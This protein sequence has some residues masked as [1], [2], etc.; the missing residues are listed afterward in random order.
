MAESLDALSELVQLRTEVEQQGGMINALVRYHPEIKT[1]ILEEF[2]K[3]E[4]MKVIYQLIDG[5]RTQKE[6]LQELQ[7]RSVPNASQ[8]TVS[9]R[10]DRLRDDLNLIVLV[11]RTEGS[12]VYIHSKLGKVLGLPRKFGKLDKLSA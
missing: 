1:Q 2:D 8:P 3:D 12:P 5:K 11:R 9:R 7:Q 6:I 10:I 4:T